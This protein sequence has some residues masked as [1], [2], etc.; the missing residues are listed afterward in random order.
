MSRSQTYEQ[1]QLYNANK[2]IN[3]YTRSYKE[4][5]LFLEC[6][7]AFIGGISVEEY[8][9]KFGILN[10]NF[11]VEE[12][13]LDK[14][15]KELLNAKIPFSMAIS[16][17][18]REP[19]SIEEQKKN[20]VFYTDYRLALLI[21]KKRFKDIKIDSKVVDFA[22]GTGILL[23]GIAEVYKEKYCDRFS[24]WIRSGLYA[25]DLSENA[26][27]GATVAIMSLTSDVEALK[28]M[29]NKWKVCD[30]LLD[31]EVERTKYDIVV[32]N[33]PWGK[34]KV[35]RHSFERMEGK[36]RVYGA[37]YLN[38]NFEKYEEEREGLAKYSR[39][40]KKKYELLDKAEPDIYMAFLQKAIMNANSNGKISFL[41]PAGLIRAQGTKN[42]REYLMEHSRKVS[43]NLFDNKANFFSIDS[44]FKFLLVSIDNESQKNNTNVSFSVSSV[45]EQNIKE[46]EKVLFNITKLKKIRPDLTIPEV[47][48]K[49]ERDIFFKIVE[50]GV[51]WGT[52]NDVW[53][54]EIC[55]EVD[56]TNDKDKFVSNHRKGYIPVIEGRMVQQHRFGVK[57]YVSGSGRS[58]L[59]KPSVKNGKAQF[60]ISREKLNEEQVKRIDVI[61]AGYCDIAGQTNERAMMSTIIP[62]G[63]ICGN[64]VPTVI[65]PNA[66]EELLYLWVGITNS[67]VFDWMIRRVI[68]TTVNYFMLFSIPMPNIGLDT[69]IAKNIISY[70]KRISAMG[71]EFYNGNVMPKMR[72]EIDLLVAKAYKLSFEDMEIIMADFPILDRKQPAISGEEKSTITTDLVLSKA[73]QMWNTG[74]NF[75]SMRYKMGKDLNAKAYIPTEMIALCKG[76]TQD[77]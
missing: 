14:M 77:G 2:I 21:A 75:Y 51:P 43:F 53:K 10:N 64:K 56:M 20:G 66:P 40:I 17:L 58:A 73:E 76:G 22:A 27:R 62:K 46:G 67:F 39:I 41:V 37:D 23:A 30:S 38:F 12:D 32:G 34:I 45:E 9:E 19:L 13:I 48:N 72:A 60:F 1:V 44:R 65:F 5:M 57:S 16:A 63:V 71:T 42:I 18:M 74:S 29:A 36:E 35:S 4:R 55:R 25:F 50:N 7:A 28:E 6:F 59:W 52:T 54:A 15:K 24:E 3:D 68:S 8:W 49:R 11:K 69:D 47:R 26:L 31:A 61:R 33:P 70:T